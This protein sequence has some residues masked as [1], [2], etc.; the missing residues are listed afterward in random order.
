MVRQN[1]KKI[2]GILPQSGYFGF[3]THHDP[4]DLEL[5]CVVKKRKI[6]FRIISDLKIQSQ[7]DHPMCSWFKRIYDGYE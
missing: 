6:C 3:L 4:N 1:S 2:R 5:I 7:A